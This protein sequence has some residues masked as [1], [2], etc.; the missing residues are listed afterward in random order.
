MRHLYGRE[1]FLQKC[2]IPYYVRSENSTADGLT[3]FQV[4]KLF[5]EHRPKLMLGELPYIREDVQR[6]LRGLDGVKVVEQPAD[7]C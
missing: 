3:K 6:A 7:E 2:V 4:E 1:M 5:A